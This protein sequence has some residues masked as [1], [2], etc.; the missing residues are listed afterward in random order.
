[1]AACAPARAWPRR[2]VRDSLRTSTLEEAPTF[3]STVVSVLEGE[4]VCGNERRLSGRVWVYAMDPASE[5][6]ITDGDIVVVGNRPD[7][8]LRVIELGAALVV[9]SNSAQP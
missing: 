6:G 7:A 3:L 4:L 8:Q 9:L 5:S 2:Y 1:P